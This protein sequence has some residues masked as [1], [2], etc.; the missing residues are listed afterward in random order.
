MA[1]QPTTVSY[2]QCVNFDEAMG[3]KACQPYRSILRN[4]DEVYCPR[5][6]QNKHHWLK[7]PIARLRAYGYTLRYRSKRVVAWGEAARPRKVDFGMKFKE[8]S[9]G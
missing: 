1:I 4:G 2:R 8:K 3:D 7:Q 5:C 9:R 6:R